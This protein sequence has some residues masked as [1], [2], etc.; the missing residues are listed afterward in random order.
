M[1]KWFLLIQIHFQKKFITPDLKGLDRLF[2][3]LESPEYLNF[4]DLQSKVL[5]KC[6]VKVF[7]KTTLKETTHFLFVS[8]F[9]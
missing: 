7:K 8:R 3:E 9:G 5:Y 1:I 6:C 4:Q 2:L